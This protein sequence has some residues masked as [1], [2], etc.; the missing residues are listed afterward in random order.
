MP[1]T[2]VRGGV[3]GTLGKIAIIVLGLG[4]A[5]LLGWVAR[6]LMYEAQRKYEPFEEECDE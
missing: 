6:A 5:F 4:V 1:E 3:M 2:V